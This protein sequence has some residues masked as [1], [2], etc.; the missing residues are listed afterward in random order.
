M[1]IMK[2]LLIVGSARCLW[3]D[4]KALGSWDHDIMV[5]NEAGCFFHRPFQHWA[6]LHPEMFRFSPYIYPRTER[7]EGV[8]RYLPRFDCQYHTQRPDLEAT[9]PL[10]VWPDSHKGGD[11]GLFALYVGLGLGYAEIVLAGVPQD[12]NRHFYDAPYEEDEEFKANWCRHYL[13]KVRNDDKAT[14]LSWKMGKEEIESKWP[15]VK[16]RSMS[17]FTRTLF[18][19]P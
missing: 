6:S 16:V 1:S 17:G 3:D 9:L 15:H 2:K 12:G 18:G 11:S 5:I 13:S 7:S 4:L 19:E 10:R 14:H 8:T